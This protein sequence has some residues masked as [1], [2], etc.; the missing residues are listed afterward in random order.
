M[1][2]YSLIFTRDINNLKLKDLCHLHHN[3]VTM[4]NKAKIQL[5]S[6]IDQILPEL[7]Q[8]FK[9][10]L[11]INV[12]YPLLKEYSCPYDI[13]NM[14]LTKLTNILHNN[15]YGRYNRNDAI[16]LRELAKNSVGIDN[17]SLSLQV[18]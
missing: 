17:P 1:G 14:H 3:L 11:H 6:Y 8:F 2:N 5:V 4:R 13:K 10:N 16:R 18:F 12:S 7:A 15:S 9:G